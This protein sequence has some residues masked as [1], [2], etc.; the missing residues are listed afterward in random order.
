MKPHTHAACGSGTPRITAFRRGSASH[1]PPEN[2]LPP[3]FD[4][5]NHVSPRFWT[6]KRRRMVGLS[7]RFSR[8][9]AGRSE[10]SDQSG[11]RENLAE[12]FES[13]DGARSSRRDV[14]VAPF[15]AMGA[16]FLLPAATRAEVKVPIAPTAS[17]TEV[18][19]AADLPASKPEEQ[20]KTEEDMITSRIYDA[21]VIGEPLAIGKDKWKV[22]EKLMNARVVYLGEAEL[23]PVRDDKELELEI[24]KSLHRRCIE[25]DKRIS[26]ALEAFPSNLQ[27]QLN[28]YMDKTYAFDFSN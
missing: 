8:V 4:A 3:Q 16:S 24:V 9:K 15:L 28:Q 13:A 20:K 10:H 18:K 27:E 21:S 26:L 5:A 2:L 12:Y 11:V 1:A 6:T 14:L 22:W 7:S 17:Q 23:V 25:N 19:T